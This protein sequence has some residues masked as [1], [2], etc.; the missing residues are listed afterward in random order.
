MEGILLAPPI[1]FVIYFM[2]VGIMALFG[3]ALA[4]KTTSSELKTSIYSSGE[5]SPERPA[6]PGYRPFFVIA[7]FFA[8]LHLGMLMLGSSFEL[9]TI[10]AIYLGG[11]ILALI[12]LI[13]G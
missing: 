3:R 4:G 12:A 13:L 6:V 2:L 7:L 9:T 11:L 5:I 8:I 1:A 10:T